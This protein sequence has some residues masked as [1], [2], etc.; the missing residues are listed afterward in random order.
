M[1][2]RHI[3]K[4]FNQTTFEQNLTENLNG[5]LETAIRSIKQLDLPKFGA[6]LYLPTSTGVLYDADTILD[7]T[8][9]AR[10]LDKFERPSPTAERELRNAA[11][12]GW[13]DLEESHVSRFDTRYLR[14]LPN[15]AGSLIAK[16]R[17]SLRTTL[18]K[19]NCYLKD[20]P[21]DFGPGE[22]YIANRGNTSFY[23]K[24]DAKLWTVTYDALQDF[25]F[26][27]ARNRGLW[28]CFKY[29]LNRELRSKTISR[30]CLY[31]GCSEKLQPVENKA[32]QITNFLYH[33]DLVL[34]GGRGTSVYKN[35]EKRRFINIEP[36]GNIILQKFVGYAIRQCLND[37]GINL[38]TGQDTHYNLIKCRV[39]TTDWKSAS[40]I[41]S[42]PLVEFLFPESVN[43]LIQRYRSPL[44]E[45]TYDIDGVRDTVSHFSHKVSSMGN[46]FTF[47][48]LTLLN[49]TFSRLFDKNAVAYGDDVIITNGRT[50]EFV[51]IMTTLGFIINDK[52]SFI[53]KS[54]RESCGGY[55]MDGFGYITCYDFKWN[56][57]FLDTIITLNKI[58]RIFLAHPNS[59][60]AEI[61][62]RNTVA[63]R[64]RIPKAFKGP[65]ACDINLKGSS[66]PNWLEIDA[67]QAGRRINDPVIR[68]KFFNGQIILGPIF[69]ISSITT[70]GD[71]K[72]WVKSKVE[73]KEYIREKLQEYNDLLPDTQY[74]NIPDYIERLQYDLR[75]FHVVRVVR[76]S[77]SIRVRK[78]NVVRD[79]RLFYTY[80]SQGHSNVT[81]RTRKAN[82]RLEYVWVLI[83]SRGQEHYTLV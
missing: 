44:V 36:F 3:K 33:F 69:K 14:G 78:K 45:L 9:A 15:W 68:D 37:V 10:V 72:F 12:S 19:F 43:K 58:R 41:I 82:R 53:N 46:G 62:H 32:I 34:Q 17:Y 22:S 6:D 57:D 27:V 39:D 76:S 66:L 11:I 25:A 31:I 83:D 16:A 56:H 77:P 29:S 28:N 24:L 81:V 35:N 1:S 2:N 60:V 38:Q 18:S 5:A 23:D 55:Y 42:N 40:D 67:R 73:R 74:V 51:R 20:A 8:I 30:S 80:L 59:K 50:D 63:L 64:D 48:L 47:E 52:K 4:V 61:L 71:F 70:T 79:P 13:I 26:L 49:V 54:M 7:A 65:A 21:I 75:D